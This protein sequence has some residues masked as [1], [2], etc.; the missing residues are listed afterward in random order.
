MS[1]LNN[2]EPTYR[3]SNTQTPVFVHREEVPTSEF[4]REFEKLARFVAEAWRD[5]HP[6]SLADFD[7][8]VA[9]VVAEMVQAGT[10]VGGPAGLELLTG[11]ASTAACKACRQVLSSL[12]NSKGHA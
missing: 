12:R 2:S 9:Y 1:S 5:D 7:D 8:C 4:E 11:G 3:H 6:H 10:A